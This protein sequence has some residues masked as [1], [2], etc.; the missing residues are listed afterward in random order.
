[1]PF[2]SPRGHWFNQQKYECS[3]TFQMCRQLQRSQ[4]FPISP[5]LVND[6]S[7]SVMKS[8]KTCFVS[9]GNALQRVSDKT[10]VIQ[11]SCH[12]EYQ[13]NRCENL[14]MIILLAEDGCEITGDKPR[15]NVLGRK[16][17]I[18]KRFFLTIDPGCRT[19]IILIIN[20]LILH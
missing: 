14:I 1:M 4:S 2:K 16:R 20:M 17:L 8:Y 9:G 15:Y 18:N 11:I 12:F 10:D 13:N 19:I 7:M 5:L 6:S 3:L